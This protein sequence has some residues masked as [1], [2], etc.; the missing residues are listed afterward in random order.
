MEK[1]NIILDL[2]AFLYGHHSQWGAIYTI[3]IIS[4]RLWALDFSVISLGFNDF[5]TTN[6]FTIQI[7]LENTSYTLKDNE[8]SIANKIRVK[9][10]KLK[11]RIP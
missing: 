9:L 6:E 2:Y 11:L 8:T 1:I 5:Y 4:F 7:H 10:V 3:R